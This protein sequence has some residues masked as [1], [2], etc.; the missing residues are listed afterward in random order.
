MIL[1]ALCDYYDALADR[2]DVVPPGWSEAKVSFALDI[3]E[4]GTLR[5]VIPLKVLPD[6]G[7]REAPQSVQVPEQVKKSSGIASNFLCE[8]SSYFLGID[9]KGKP[10]R[11]RQCFEAAKTL[12]HEILDGTDCAAA[13]AVLAFF[14]GWQ[15]ESAADDPVLAPYLDEIV[16]GANLIFSVGGAYAQDDPDIRAAWEDHRA[17]AS[18]GSAVGRCL[19]TGQLGPVARLHPAIKGVRDAQSSGA[20][21]VSFNAAAFESYGHEG[22]ETGQG[23]N[24]PVSEEA[25]FKYGA[26]L[27]RLVGD[28]EHTQYIGDTAVIYWAEDAEPKYQDVFD[29][30]VLGG[31]HDTISEG[32][33]Q[34]AVRALASGS[35]ADVN[36][37]PL[38]PKNNFYVLGLAPNAARLSVRFF[39]QNTFGRMMTNVQAH[40]D[41]LLIVRPA[42]VENGTLPLWRL[43]NETVN[44]NSR[45]KKAS[46]S[47]A[48]AVVRAVLTDGPY[49]VSLLEQTM[50]RI[51]A[52]QN[53]TY[54]R[55]A[56]L[57]AFFLKNRE[58]KVPEE[59][60]KVELNE[61]SSHL[62]YVLG[63]LFA[64]LERV[65]SAANPGINA[66]IKDKYFNSACAT[67]ATI[68]PLL[69]K[70]SQSHLRKLDGG[71]KTYYEKM[72]GDLEGRIHETLPARMPLADQGTFYLGYYHQVQKF[73]E[74]KDK[75][76][77][78]N[79]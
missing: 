8:N 11:S 2:G 65:Q 30:A 23:L 42:Y 3:D 20:S 62:S 29:C 50:L 22:K 41:R 48:G 34:S 66:T 77:N 32:T 13:R 37:I 59:V 70:L 15:P 43:L 60:L 38:D 44:P 75:G 7:K 33:L 69:T 76:G 31:R 46:P 6:G 4:H 1:K 58:F 45:D 18:E 12:H 52:E 19:V 74:K 51:R 24:S 5:G 14:D 40:Y 73:F 36:G 72:I 64:V 53:V 71:L 55:A 27:N 21:L 47:M 68:F 16:K 25:A 10:E 35:P 63:R 56:I 79:V 67:P 17:S 9:N 26:A 49:P 61:E 57:K 78:E 54:G 39:L 28:R